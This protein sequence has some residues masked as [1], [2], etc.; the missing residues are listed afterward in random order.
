MIRLYIHNHTH[1][2]TAD[3]RRIAMRVAKD[4][5]SHRMPFPFVKLEIAYNRQ[6]NGKCSGWAYLGHLPARITIP[7][8]SIDRADLALC[9]AHE[10]AHACLGLDHPQMKGLASYSRIG[11][12]RMLYEWAEGLPLG[13]RKERKK[14]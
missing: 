4:I 3:L 13:K 1:W 6:K 10:M 7:R 2:R 14:A 5:L 9:M 12:W 8:D 11:S